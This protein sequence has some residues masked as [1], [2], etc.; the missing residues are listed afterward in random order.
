MKLIHSSEAVDISGDDHTFS[1]PV[2]GIYVGT[3]GTVVARLRGDAADSTWVAQSGQYL[4]GDFTIVRDAGGGT[5][6]ADMVGVSDR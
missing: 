3:A 1:I 6:A 2:S 5:D 4:L